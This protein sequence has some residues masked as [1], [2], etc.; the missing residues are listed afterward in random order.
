MIF[1]G[2]ENRQGL[3]KPKVA[4]FCFIFYG[5][6]NYIQTDK[7]EIYSERVAVHGLNLEIGKNSTKA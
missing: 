2:L 1:I 6:Q 4:I 7:L 3:L 5:K